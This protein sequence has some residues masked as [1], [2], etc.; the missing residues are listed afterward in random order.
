MGKRDKE[1]LEKF[2]K[3]NYK[4]M[5]RTCLRYAIEKF[6]EGKRKG[7]LKGNFD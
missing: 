2:I 1:L 5:P 6:E 3:D 7:I 4:D